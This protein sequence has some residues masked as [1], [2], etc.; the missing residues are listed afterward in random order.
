MIPSHRIN[1]GSTMHWMSRLAFDLD[2]LVIVAIISSCHF[3]ECNLFDMHA[4]ASKFTHQSKIHLWR[5][6]AVRKMCNYLWQQEITFEWTDSFEERTFIFG[7][8]LFHC[9]CCGGLASRMQMML[10]LIFLHEKLCF[11]PPARCRVSFATYDSTNIY[12]WWKTF[13]NVSDL[14]IHIYLLSSFSVQLHWTFV[15]ME[16]A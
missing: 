3:A 13:L 10:W 14:M 12:S 6:I 16:V 4:C 2:G 9:M 5:L 7:C 8:L 1:G 11:A 15:F